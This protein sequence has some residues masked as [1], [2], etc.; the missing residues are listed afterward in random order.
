MALRV[1]GGL[2]EMDMG[3][4]PYERSLSS[5]QIPGGSFICA[6]VCVCV[7]HCVRESNSRGSEKEGERVE[8]LGQ[9]ALARRSRGVY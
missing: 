1:G 9:A 7:C 5:P 2:N 6:S 4:S 3:K 8:N